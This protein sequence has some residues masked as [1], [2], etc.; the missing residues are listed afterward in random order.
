MLSGMKLPCGM[1]AVKEVA[2]LC[3]LKSL[4]SPFAQEVLQAAADT[5]RVELQ[6]D[7][8]E[9]CKLEQLSK[10]KEAREFIRAEITALEACSTG[11]AT[12]LSVEPAAKPASNSHTTAPPDTSSSY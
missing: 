6:Q 10:T 1:E 4:A 5:L 11:E 2:E 12:P 9:L 7:I 3:R 8:A